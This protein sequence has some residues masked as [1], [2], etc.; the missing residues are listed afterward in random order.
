MKLR[1]LLILLPA[2]V[3]PATCAFGQQTLR[4]TV[5]DENGAPLEAAAVQLLRGSNKQLV[6]YAL[7][8][9]QGL[10]SL[11]TG[12]TGD[13]LRI[14]VSVLGY[15]PHEQPVRPG[16]TLLIRIRQQA[17]NLRE[18]EIRPGR[19]WGRQD[20]I[21][22]DVA[23][24]LSPKDES[25]RDVIRK[26]PGIN[27]DE[28]GAISYNGK[29]ISNF[30]VEGMDL[31]GGRY[32]QM[33]NNLDAKAVETVQILENHQP[34]R[35]LQDKVKTENIA[36]NLKLRP[37]FRDKWMVFLQGGL[38]ATPLLWKGSLN[39]M[40]LSRRSQSAYLYK[41]NNTG[42]DVTEEQNIL[43]ENQLGQIRET[44]T[45][46]FLRQPSLM[47]PLKKERLLF[48]EVHSLSA[49]RLYRPDETTRLRIHAG[50]T[51]DRREQERGS[52]TTYYRTDDTVRIAEQ[53]H[54]RLRSGQAELGLSLEKNADEQYLT[55]RF[56]AFGNHH[57]SLSAYTGNRPLVQEIQT[58]EAGLRNDF[59]IIRNSGSYTLEAYSLLRYNH[60]PSRLNIGNESQALN[61]NELYADH[62][63]AI[64][65]KKGAVSHQYSAGVS[66]QRTNIRNG[67][68]L[69]AIPSWQWN[70]SKWNASLGIPLVWTAY[71]GAD[72]SR[73]AVN[74]S[75]SL[76]YK[77]NYAWSFSL[78]G[79]YRE[80]YG[81][82]TDLYTSPYRTDY[83]S[84]V[85]NKGFLS[86]RQQQTYSAYTE[87]KRTVQ[88][89][90]ASLSFRYH[91]QYANRMYEQIF[92]GEQITLQAHELGNISSGES[93]RGTLSKGF[94]DWRLNTSLDYTLSRNRGE[95]WVHGQRMPFRYDRMQ[96]E[97]KITWTPL[98]R[99]ELGYQSTFRYGSSLIGSSTRLDPLW[100][101]VQ[102]L[103]LTCEIADIEINLAGEH[104]HNDV[105]GDRSVDAFFADLSL[106]WKPRRWQ[107]ELTATNLSDRREYRYTEYSDIQSY[108]SWI[109]IRG[110]EFLLSA[111]Y[112]FR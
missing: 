90:F 102:K 55:N 106:R 14:L 64:H 4:G 84:T 62:S 82:V 11:T 110:R 44:E 98:R 81:D 63:L 45:P 50:Y 65:R 42:N 67:F 23:Q 74:P 105:S 112:A 92:E 66:G 16:E 29:D 109:H 9:A 38:G 51:H 108:T 32:G 34:I 20:T 1:T 17:F 52:E 93:L 69:Y 15:A 95:Q 5:S 100:N 41:G 94:Y 31:M 36:L 77:Y 68:S 18:V 91:R 89:F 71:P 28:A 53:S 83:R 46:S 79:S 72:F 33:T 96:Y 103:Q 87:Y 49:N 26:L 61:L 48:N 101:V 57:S 58:P 12:E 40:Q 39:A 2:A 27:I 99:F 19:V 97:P 3:F 47:A 56:R 35:I 111:R 60:R 59:R 86:L 73:A 22:Y 24:F 37:E 107:F 13:S 70:V 76:R 6:N 30:Y 7:T 54:T 85:V 88:E 43:F 75:L 21:N 10:F 8:D 80:S 78:S 25:I 104:Y